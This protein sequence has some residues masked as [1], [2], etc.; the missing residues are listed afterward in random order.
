MNSSFPNRWSL[1]YLKFTK[2]VTNIIDE[3]KYK[4]R[5]QEPQE[6][7]RPGNGQYKNTQYKILGAQ[8]GPTGA[9][10]RPQPPSW[11]KT[12]SCSVRVEALQP[13]NGS[14]RETNKSQINTTMKQRWGLDRNVPRPTPGDPRGS[15]QH[16]RN[17]GAEENQ[18]PNPGGPS[19]KQKSPGPNQPKQTA[20]RRG[21][22]SH[23]Q[24]PIR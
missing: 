11:L 21:H 9:Q 6:K 3:P 16:H 8:T 19:N 1:S 4:H 17:T 24:K 20:P 14:P 10:P 13:T 2:Y 22:L 7:H 15:E 12:H 23:E 18:Q 5:Q